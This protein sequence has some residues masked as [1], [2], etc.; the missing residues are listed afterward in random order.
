M[1]PKQRRQ[2]Q[3]ST[4][5]GEG[6]RTEEIRYPVPPASAA[7]WR[8]YQSARVHNPGLVFERFVRDWGWYE[9]RGD[10]EAKQKAWKEIEPIVSRGDAELLE[11]FNTRWE[12]DAAHVNANSFALETDWRFIT[13]L[14]R[15]GPL[16]AGF[17]F[18]RYGFPILPGSSVKGI[19]RAYAFYQLAEALQAQLEN[20]P[21]VA[22]PDAEP[23]DRKD[24]DKASPLDR[25]ERIVSKDDDAKYRR[26]YAWYYGANAEA[27]A[28]AKQFR[29]VFGTTG[30]AGGAIFLDAIPKDKLVLQL[31]I[32]NPHF[33]DYYT[34][35]SN[36]VAP[37]DWQSPNPVFFLTVAPN[38]EFRFAVGWRGD[39]D[40]NA[41]RL[42]DLA[43][44]WLT[45]GLTELGAGAKTS[46]GYG[47]FKPDG[48]AGKEYRFSISAIQGET[49]GRKQ[50][51]EFEL[52]GDTV[53]KVRRV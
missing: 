6:E 16:E 42:R 39:L 23:D 24:L 31:D 19:A 17:T 9:Q 37:T 50:S 11:K 1:N 41:M 52:D 44:S 45:G 36:R 14:G 8:K 30:N 47:Y 5:R 2:N 35:K 26:A 4:A 28:L 29:A 51:V 38:T 40:A 46:A 34:D 15:K 53:V 49:P 3:P 48:A 21:S 13:G 22:N 33:P 27:F 20:I 32:M 7:A 18:N 12:H 43:K 10:K 25:L